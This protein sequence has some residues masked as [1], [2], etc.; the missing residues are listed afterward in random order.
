MDE[1]RIKKDTLALIAVMLVGTALGVAGTWVTRWLS[2]PSA[3]D[4][5]FTAAA[6]S[7]MFV[8]WARR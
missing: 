8:A 7:A 5:A 3:L 1:I 4:I 6:I 2:N